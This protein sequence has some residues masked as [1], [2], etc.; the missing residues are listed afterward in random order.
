ME[1]LAAPELW[2]AFFTLTLLELVLGIDNIIFISILCDK[3]PPEQRNKARR[4]G[5]FLAMFMRIGLL[6]VLSLIVGLVTP[7]FHVGQHGVSGR[8]LILLGGGVFLIW[9]S[10]REI[11]QLLE[12]DAGHSSSA[13]P[14][15]FF[16]V[17]VQIIIIDIV[18][19]LDS[20]ITAVGM[21]DELS[22]MVAAVIASVGLMMAFSGTIARFVNAHPTIKMLALGFLFVIGVVLV[23]DGLGH[24]IPKGYVY[25]A[26]AFALT[27]EILNIRMRHSSA[28]PIDLRDSYEPELPGS[29]S[30]TLGPVLSY[31][32]IAAAGAW[33]TRAFGLAAPRTGIDNG[34]L[35]MMASD[36]TG[37][38]LEPHVFEG[39]VKRGCPTVRVTV[40][41]LQ[42]HFERAQ[43]SGARI[44]HPPEDAHG[45]RSYEAL[46]VDG[47]HW[48]FVQR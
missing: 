44:L 12:G 36:G 28:P 20:I 14:S 29:V 35:L 19:S 40:Q 16:A 48:R 34:R 11:H 31:D 27:I 39:E 33:L 9:K 6:S 17:L 8:D 24:H 25:G 13:V 32:D 37:V 43:A 18:F 46:D 45:E 7:W 15:K 23:A 2:V 1:I 22:V 5:L 10:T 47:H 3:L 26:M 38:H 4:V 42:A 21:V 41:D 30:T